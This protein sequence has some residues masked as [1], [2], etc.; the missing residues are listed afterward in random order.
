M[1][2]LLDASVAV[3]FQNKTI[4][5]LKLREKLECLHRKIKPFSKLEVIL[6]GLN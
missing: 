3:S 5:C 4:I 2:P 6:E 1:K